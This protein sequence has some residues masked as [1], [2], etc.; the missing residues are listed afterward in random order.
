MHNLIFSITSSSWLTPA[1]VV[2]AVILVITILRG[3]ILWRALSG[4]LLVA[5]IL[6]PR[7][8]WLVLSHS[9]PDE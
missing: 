3:N 7:P 5:V 4:L 2:A 8:S 9:G 6:D 1:V